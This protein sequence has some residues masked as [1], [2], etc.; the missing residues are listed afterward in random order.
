MSNMVPIECKPSTGIG[1]RLQMCKT[2]V[3]HSHLFT[4]SVPMFFNIPG[5]QRLLVERVGYNFPLEEAPVFQLAA[6]V[7]MPKKNLRVTDANKNN[8]NRRFREIPT[9]DI[10]SQFKH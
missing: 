4:S 1:V 3:K 5:G 2:E 6:T 9:R 10:K 8:R 7:L